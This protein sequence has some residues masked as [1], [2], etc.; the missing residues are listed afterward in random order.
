[1][2]NFSPPRATPPR[3]GAVPGAPGREAKGPRPPRGYEICLGGGSSSRRRSPTHPGAPV[4]GPAASP[5]A[6]R[7][8]PAPATATRN[9]PRAPVCCRGGSRGAGGSPSRCGDATSISPNQAPLL[10]PENAPAQ[11]LAR[12]PPHPPKKRQYQGLRSAVSPSS[13]PQGPHV[14]A[15]MSGSGPSP[16]T[17]GRMRPPGGGHQGCT[18]GTGGP[19]R[20]RSTGAQ[21]VWGM[22]HTGQTLR[23]GSGSASEV[24]PVSPPSWSPTT[25][26]GG[27]EEGMEGGMEGG[28]KPQPKVLKAAL[29]V[30]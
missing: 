15:G 9:S 17:T 28:P 23:G 29:G 30:S 21:K 10:M 26:G 16:C 6:A 4:P 5:S 19:A 2:G 11:R 7:E 13:P 14:M 8:Q 27:M 1:M 22:G 3:D 20:C 12:F 25:R 18:R 24:S